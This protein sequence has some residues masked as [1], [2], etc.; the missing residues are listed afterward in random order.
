MSEEVK[1]RVRR[2]NAEVKAEKKAKML[3]E[4]EKHKEAIKVLEQKIKELDK[5]TK[6]DAQIK[7]ELLKFMEKKSLQEL[8]DFAG[9]NLDELRNS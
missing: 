4:I 5:P 1:T 3:A 2:S 7:K 9:K 6:T 8:A